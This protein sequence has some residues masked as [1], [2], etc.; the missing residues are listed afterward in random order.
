MVLF[1]NK[2]PNYSANCNMA[3]YSKK[4]LID[5]LGY[6]SSD[7]VYTFEAPDWITMYLIECGVTPLRQTPA[8]WAHG[9][10][11]NT[12]QLE[13]FLKTIKLD[14]VEKGVWVSWPKKSS[15]TETDLTEQTFRDHILA[16]GWV[17]TKVCA[18]DEM[19]S[20]LKFLRRK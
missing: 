13:K 6:K 5:K 18:V 15:N 16:L 1:L 12:S 7:T 17:D 9:F 8:A 14:Q 10:F 2:S 3:G 11:M 19:W 20:G 4:A